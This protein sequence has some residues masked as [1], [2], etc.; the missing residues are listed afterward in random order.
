M[1]LNKY[2]A[3]SGICS[4]RKAAQIIKQGLVTVNNIVTTNPAYDVQEHDVVIYGEKQI[5]LEKKIYIL[6]HKPIGFVTTAADEFGRKT[7][8]DLV[9]NATQERLYPVGRLDKDTTGL[10]I[11]TN[12]GDLA[13]RLAHPRYE[14]SKVYHVMLDR[15]VKQKDLQ[16]LLKG[17]KLEDGYA[18]VD[19]IAFLDAEYKS[20][21][22]ELHSGK[23]RIIRRLLKAIGYTV[24]ALKRV[25]YAGLTLKGL[26]EGVWRFLTPDEVSMLM[27]V[28]EKGE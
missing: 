18:Y 26:K 8:L 24:V 14:V 22:I 28:S 15:A 21:S 7:V 16:Q 23:K 6:L 11:I 4:R 10:L 27:H 17:I 5:K 13:Q 25:S 12:D 1:F 3:L 9:K 2:L 19:S 20:I